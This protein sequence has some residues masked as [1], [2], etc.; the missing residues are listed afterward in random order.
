MEGRL[1]GNEFRTTI[2]CVDQYDERGVPAGRL[3]NPYLA[4][5][6][7]FRS[8]M[9]FIRKMEE[10]LNGTRLPQAYAQPR[11]FSGGCGVSVEE[12]PD[13]AVREGRIGTFTLRVL[14]RQNSSWQG[15]VTWLEG[16]KEE[17][18]RSALELFHLM[19]SALSDELAEQ[20]KLSAFG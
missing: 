17:K 19:D 18:F 20:N 8:L 14:F 10:L 1:Y 13:A 7:Q 16:R 4:E 11:S 5:G 3:Y 9:E 6:E 12:P 15:S 2:V